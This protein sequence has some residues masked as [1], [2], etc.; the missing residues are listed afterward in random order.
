MAHNLYYV[1]DEV[2]FTSNWKIGTIDTDPITVKFYFIKPDKTPTIYVFGTDSELVKVSTGNYSVDLILS[3]EGI[4]RIRWEG[5]GG[6]AASKE[7]LVEARQ[8]SFL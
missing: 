3:N 1:L 4:W 7:G 5:V 2:K 6:A 8:S